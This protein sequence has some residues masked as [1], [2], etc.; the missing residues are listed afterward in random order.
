MGMYKMGMQGC[1]IQV[2]DKQIFWKTAS[3][4][5]F[6][7]HQFREPNISNICPLNITY[8]KLTKNI[9]N[10]KIYFFLI[11]SNQQNVMITAE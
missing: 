2:K 4:N 11:G 7:K 3:V 9:I 10:S 8:F 1:Q 6:T 5:Q